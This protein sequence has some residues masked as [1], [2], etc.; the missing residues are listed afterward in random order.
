MNFWWEDIYV[1]VRNTLISIDDNFA[2]LLRLILEK[3]TEDVYL[4]VA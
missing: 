1:I 4:T 2:D 3:N